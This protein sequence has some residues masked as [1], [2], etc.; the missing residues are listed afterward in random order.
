ME[1]HVTLATDLRT[2]V[3]K[4]TH[5]WRRPTTL[6]SYLFLPKIYFSFFGGVTVTILNFCAMP[7][8]AWVCVQSVAEC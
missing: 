2:T 8:D 6:G 7:R 5:V 1:Q 4:I 3:P